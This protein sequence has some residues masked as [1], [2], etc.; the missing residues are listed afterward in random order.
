MS[1][2]DPDGMIP[3]LSAPPYSGKPKII[4]IMGTWCPNCRDETAF[5]LDYLSKN[6]DP[7]FEIIGVSFER[8]TDPEKAKNVIRT[9]REKL[10]IPYTIVYGGSNNKEEASKAL[11]MLDE[12]IAFPTLL[13]L[14]A[15]NRVVSIHTGFSGPATSGYDD[16]VKE[17][18]Q[19]VASMKSA[20][21]E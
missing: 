7:G 6:P 11:P 16:F 1:F 19:L 18:D 5:L 4:Q 10:D 17:F 14:D 13:F 2:A 12:V 20:T 3:D 21:H 9:Y 15:D 8:H